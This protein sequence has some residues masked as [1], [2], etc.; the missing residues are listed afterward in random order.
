MIN[1]QKYINKHKYF[2]NRDGD[3]Y[4]INIIIFYRGTPEA[5]AYA[6]RLVSKII[7]MDGVN[8]DQD[9]NQLID[10]MKNDLRTSVT[11]HR[12]SSSGVTSHNGASSAASGGR[13]WK[14][15]AAPPPSKPAWKTFPKPAVSFDFVNII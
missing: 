5:Q 13:S 10:S 11:S 9:I 12:P 7:S 3:M 6:Q 8:M 14:V 1:I 4:I 15:K 2:S